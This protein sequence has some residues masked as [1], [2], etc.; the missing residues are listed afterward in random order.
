MATQTKL[1]ENE[2]QGLEDW[3]KGR[4]RNN[5]YGGVEIGAMQSSS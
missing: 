2:L 4:C 5:V 3:H 1:W